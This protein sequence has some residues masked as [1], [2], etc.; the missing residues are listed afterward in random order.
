MQRDGADDAADAEQPTKLV[1]EHV[2]LILRAQVTLAATLRE[3]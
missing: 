3:W 2:D 1:T